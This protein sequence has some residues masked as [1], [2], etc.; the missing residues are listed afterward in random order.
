MMSF[1][2]THP[3]AVEAFFRSSVVLTFALPK[4]QL[5]DLIP[6]CLELDTFKDDW[7]FLAI[8]MVDTKGLRPKGFSEIFGKDFFLIGYR[9]FVRYKTIHGKNLRGLYIIGSETNKKSMEYAGKI[10]TKY[11]YKTIEII[12]SDSE[13]H[14]V[15]SSNLNFNVTIGKN[16]NEI[17]LPENSPFENCKEAR[18]YAGPLPFTFSFD[19]SKSE[20]LIVEGVRENWIPRPI[21]ILDYSFTFLE[22]Y[23]FK[24]AILANAFIIENIPYFWKKGKIEK[25]H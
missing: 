21:E 19:K 6:E 13:H 14:K 16:S 9:I 1:L 3:F 7:A 22:K 18:R 11:K 24:N 5:Q 8:A 17:P 15:I 2:K 20:V 25:W 10:F 12:E 4:I 23:N